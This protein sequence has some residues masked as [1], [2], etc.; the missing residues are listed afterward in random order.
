MFDFE[1]DGLL[2]EERFG[3]LDHFMAIISESGHEF[4]AYDDALEFL[5]G[6]RDAVR[7]AAK[8]AQLFPR[9]AADP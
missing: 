7:R 9:G 3:D 1:R 4:R 6:R 2:P 5:A 8:L